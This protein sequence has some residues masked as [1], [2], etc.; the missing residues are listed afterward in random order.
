MYEFD[1]D[2]PFQQY[3]QQDMPRCSPPYVY[4]AHLAVQSAVQALADKG[5]VYVWTLVEENDEDG[6]SGVYASLRGAI[7]GAM[8]ITTDDLVVTDDSVVPSPEGTRLYVTYL[9]PDTTWEFV[10]DPALGNWTGFRFKTI[11]GAGNERRWTAS[12]QE[13]L[14]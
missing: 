5:Q 3:Y 1:I 11:D 2:H 13:L 9:A 14:P 6:L 10:T 12:W 4:E 7:E 8:S